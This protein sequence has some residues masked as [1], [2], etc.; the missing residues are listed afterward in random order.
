MAFDPTILRGLSGLQ[1]RARYLV[2]GALNGLHESPFRGFS[3]EFSEYRDYQQG[4]DLRHL[5]WRFYARADKLCIRRYE[6]ETNLNF[7]VVCDSSRS[8]AYVGTR[9]WASKLEAARTL[10]AAFAWLL[11]KQK[12]TVGLLT[13]SGER[14]GAGQPAAGEH[15]RLRPT[16]GL[17]YVR[18]SQ[19]PSQFGQ[20]LGVLEPLRPEGGPCLAALLDHA[21]VLIP[22]RSV[23]LLLSDLLDPNPDLRQQLEHLRY[24]GHEILVLQILDPDEIDFPFTEAGI[25]ED[26]ESGV[27]RRVQPSR[28]RERYLERFR[29][30]QEENLAAFRAMEVLH[31]LVPTDL[32]PGAAI[33]TFLSQRRLF[34]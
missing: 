3:S 24:L 19:K 28:V 11:L 16:P 34:A 8:M 23:I 25:F 15:S 17:A 20:I 18:H 27:R 31:Q 10:A 1:F 29:E 9:A 22:R 32:D 26:L 2:E 14:S 7:Y 13:Y 33:A 21:R 5:D 30:F 12:D 4:D 6:Q